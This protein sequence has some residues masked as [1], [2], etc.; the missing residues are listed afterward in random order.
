MIETCKILLIMKKIGVVIPVYNSEKYLYEC[1]SSLLAQSYKSFFAVIVD[2]GSTDNS[3]HMCDDFALIDKRIVVIHKTNC[4]Q[5]D[6]RNTGLDYL[7]KHVDFDFLAFV[8]SDDILEKEYLESLVSAI[9][10]CDIV[11]SSFKRYHNGAV[12]SLNYT[13]DN[14][15]VNE[16][17]FWKLHLPGSITIVPW[18]KLYKKSIFNDIRYPIVKCCEDGFVI[19]HLIGKAKKIRLLSTDYYLYR[20]RDKSVMASI[21]FND[22]EYWFIQL[23]SQVDKIKYFLDKNNINQLIV[24]HSKIIDIIPKIYFSHHKKI[25]SLF[26]DVKYCYYYLLNSGYLKNSF[27]WTF[28]YK[29]TFIYCLVYM[30]RHAKIE[31]RF[32]KE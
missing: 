25:R 16:T 1:L 5:A 10:D 12:N 17:E 24:E 22:K 28:F 4:G 32:N 26:K 9:D 13:L 7:Y 11:I 20:I 23:E 2:D 30:I 31:R 29:F 19:H 18:N 15:V 14:L 6:A 21:D 3:S 27:R 8:D